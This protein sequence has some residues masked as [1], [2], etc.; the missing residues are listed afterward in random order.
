MCVRVRAR[1]PS[2][3]SC[4][5]LST[6]WTVTHQTSSVH[7]ILHPRILEW[8]AMFSSRGIFPTQ[9]SE[10]RLSHLL[11]WQ[12]GFFCFFFLPLAPPGKPVVYLNMSGTLFEGT[13]F[14][15]QGQINSF[16]DVIFSECLLEPWRAMKNNGPDKKGQDSPKLLNISY[17]LFWD[18]RNTAMKKIHKNPCPNKEGKGRGKKWE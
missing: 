12:V 2:C 18:P 9:G 11:Q 3:L 17:A 7:G 6:L 15:I 1:A 4:S 13:T 16:F 8:G 5:T 14:T 10:S